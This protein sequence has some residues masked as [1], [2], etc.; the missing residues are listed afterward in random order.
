MKYDLVP[1]K[2]EIFQ[3]VLDL[4][5]LGPRIPG[6]DGDR[7]AETYLRDKLLE[8]E[9][10]DVHVEPIDITLWL[11]KHWSLEVLPKGEEARSVPCFYVPYT[12]PTS[13]LEGELV[14]VGEGLP[15]DFEKVDVSGKIVMVSVRFLPL[16][17]SLLAPF[18]HFVYDP[19]GTL[20]PEWAHPATWIRLNCMGMGL[21][22]GGYDAYETAREHGAIGFIGVLEDYPKL[23]EELTYY[24]PYDGIL[25]PMPGLWVSKETGDLLKSMLS[26]DKV[27]A[28]ITLE[29]E[30]RPTITHNIYGVLPGK[31]DEV[32][33]VHSHHDGPFQSAVEDASGCSEVLALA[34]YFTRCREQ[35]KRTLLFLFTAGHFYGGAEGIGQKAFIEAHKSDVIARTLIDI[36]I[37]HVAK[38]CL[39]KDGIAVMTENVEPR[40]LFTTDNPVLID[41][42]KKAIIK[43]DVERILV[44]PTTTPIN[45]PTD[46]HLF[47][48]NG[49]PIYSLISGP[50]YLFDVTDTPDKVAKDQLEVLTKMF[51]D[52]IRELDTVPREEI[53]AKE[54]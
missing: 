10:K 4:Y 24:A 13:G 29:A 40:G 9:F 25:R 35:I 32:M 34:K 3:W 30:I 53:R 18:A 1:S 19:K 39:V 47:W 20:T 5:S 49:I 28:K 50:V 26:K 12:A 45:V 14:Y 33:I 37:E 43:N 41:I 16:Q 11:A 7:K 23:G 31:T 8:F 42:A 51:I 54:G 36:A 21:I 48:K 15:E 2:D 44:L 38:E 27:S 52:I 22:R 46:A 17:V 6:S